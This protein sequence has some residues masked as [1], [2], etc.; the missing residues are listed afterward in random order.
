MQ[1]D[2]GHLK[3]DKVLGRYLWGGKSGGHRIHRNLEDKAW[4]MCGNLENSR[5]LATGPRSRPPTWTEQLTP[6][7]AL[8]VSDLQLLAPSFSPAHLPKPGEPIMN[9][10]YILCPR[11]WWKRHGPFLRSSEWW[12]TEDKWARWRIPPASLPLLREA[13]ILFLC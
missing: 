4:R 7:T 5:C 11:S 8:E 6:T 9:W 10:A 2:S 12:E 13:P 3:E 1:A